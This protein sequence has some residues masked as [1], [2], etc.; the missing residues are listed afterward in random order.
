MKCIRCDHD[1]KYKD[2]SNRK[3]PNCGGLFAFEPRAGDPLTDMAFKRSIERV[4]SEGRVRWGV[5]HL[6]YEVCRRKRI[7]PGAPIGL[8]IGAGA[9]ALGSTILGGAVKPGFLLGLVPAGL[10]AW[11]AYYLYSSSPFVRM[12]S[13]TFRRLYDQWV[14]AHGA[15]AG[16]IGRKPQPAQAREVESDI[17]DY[18]FD[19]AVICDRARTVDLL[20]ANNFHFENNCAVLSVDGYPAGPFETV[21][22]MLKRNPRLQVYTLHDATLKGCNLAQR[23]VTD[24]AWFAGQARVIDVGLRPSHGPRFRGLLLESKAPRVP[25]DEAITAWEAEWLAKHE[26]EVAAIRPEQVLKRLFRTI[27]MPI[28]AAAFAGA[29]VLYLPARTERPPVG[30]GGGGDGGG[31]DGGGFGADAKDADGP[32]DSFG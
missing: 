30:D 18:S 10:M 29:A 1:S 4:S 20:L 3:C 8:A 23:L 17:A 31:G 27:N 9:L 11:G 5:E 24:P 25:A 16:V 28:D 13:S 7:Q 6:Y 22:K 19:R 21:R 12:D 32:A 14:A 15:P 26:L 2:R